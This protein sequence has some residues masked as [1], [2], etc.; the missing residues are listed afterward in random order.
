MN[1]TVVPAQAGTQVP[2]L[3][4]P[5]TWI[6]ASAGMTTRGSWLRACAGMTMAGIRIR[7]CAQMTQAGAPP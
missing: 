6:P 3:S 7:A 2:N 4:A 1:V 5:R